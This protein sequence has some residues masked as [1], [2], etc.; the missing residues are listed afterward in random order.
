[1]LKKWRK[2]LC[3]EFRAPGK[4]GNPK[5]SGDTLAKCPGLVANLCAKD[6]DECDAIRKQI[7]KTS[8]L[9]VVQHCS[10]PYLNMFDLAPS[11]YKEEWVEGL[12]G[13]LPVEI[14]IEGNYNSMCHGNQTIDIDLAYPQ[15]AGMNDY[16][17]S[18]RLEWVFVVWATH[19]V[20]DK[21]LKFN[22]VVA[23]KTTQQYSFPIQGGDE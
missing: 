16:D 8:K 9:M 22:L 15:L 10:Y 14:R 7:A 21:V 23:G 18:Q 20:T 13:C 19:R 4:S 1:M 6:G 3:L 17:H 12:W 5:K 11:T 2:C